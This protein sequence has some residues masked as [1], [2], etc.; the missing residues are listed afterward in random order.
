MDDKYLYY[1]EFTVP[2]DYEEDV[3]GYNWPK[4]IDG[5]FEKPEQAME[6]FEEIWDVEP[7]EWKEVH[8]ESYHP[9][10]WTCKDGYATIREVYVSSE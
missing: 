1:L 9:R 6:Y 8:F 7:E 5:I 3:D 4:V 10:L 2:G